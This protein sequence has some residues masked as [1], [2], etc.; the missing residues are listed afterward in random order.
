M[1]A[2]ITESTPAATAA[3]KGGASYRSHSSRVWW[4]CGSSV[5]LSSVVS[6]CPGKCL[7]AVAIPALR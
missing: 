6:P 5:W 2:V 3:R 4:M 7:A 1:W